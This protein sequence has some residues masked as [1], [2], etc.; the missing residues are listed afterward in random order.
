M[1]DGFHPVSTFD[2]SDRWSLK[3]TSP[4]KAGGR[5]CDGVV[6]VTFRVTWHIDI[7]DAE[8]MVAAAIQAFVYIQRH[9]TTANVFDVHDPHGQSTR[10]DLEQVLASDPT[11]GVLLDT[12]GRACAPR[13]LLEVGAAA[14]GQPAKLFGPFE[15]S[16]ER[17]VSERIDDAS[18]KPV[19]AIAVTPRA[20]LIEPWP[21]RNTPAGDKP[22]T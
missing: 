1:H 11:A 8:D 21:D 14:D 10:V 19:I 22:V 20:L 13:Y 4:T 16:D 6:P 9:G 5:R 17:H 2:T 15:P 3:T 12:L 18:R 7:D